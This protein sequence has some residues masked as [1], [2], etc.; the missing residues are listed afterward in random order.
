[1]VFC[2]IKY[3]C[4][5][6]LFVQFA[7]SQTENNIYNALD[8]FVA[9]PT[10]SNLEK[11]SFL[12]KN[13]SLKAKTEPELLALVIL[14]C[15]K[16]YYE[17]QFGQINQA[18]KTYEKSWRIFEINN[19]KNYDIIE[20]CL[21]PLGNLYTKIGDYDSAE[22]TIKQYFFIA[23]Q[24]NNQSQKIASILNLAIVYQSSGRTEASI[25]LVLKTIKEEKLTATE[26]SLLWNNLA[27]NYILN[28]EFEKAKIV[29]EKIIANVKN[30]PNNEAIL[31]NVHRNLA[32][33]YLHNNDFISARL[34][35]NKGKKYILKSKTTSS[36]DLIKCNLEE[37]HLLLKEEKYAACKNKIHSILEQLLPNFDPKKDILPKKNTL[38]AETILLDVFD[39]LA[40]IKTNQKLYQ[41]ALA[42]YE[43]SIYVQEL[44]QTQVLYENS[45]IIN[46][47]ENNIRTEKCLAIYHSLFQK[48]KNKQYVEKAF[49]LSEKSKS[50]VLKNFIKKNAM[51]PIAQKKC[52]EQ[53]QA[54][55]NTIVLEQ[56]KQGKANISIINRNIIIQNKLML[57]LK[58]IQDNNF[59]VE[60]LKI[61]DLYEKLE[62]D[63][64]NLITY[65]S[66][67]EKLYCFKII[68]NKLQMLVLEKGNQIDAFLNYF[69][70]SD[71]ISDDVSG[72]TKSSFNLFRYL[73]LKSISKRKNVIIIP[74]GKLNFIPFD[75]LLTAETKSQNF[76]SLPY[77]IKQNTIS[78]ANSVS[79]YMEKSSQNKSKNTVLGVFPVFKNTIESLPYSQDELKAIKEHFEGTFL[80]N[81]KAT[82]AN[83][84]KKSN[85]YS[86]LHLSTHATSG[87]I[88]EPATIRFFDKEVMY[89]ELYS[90]KINPDL[91]VLSACET[92]IG[93]W[94][95]NEGS[96]SVARGFQQAGAQNLLFSLWKVNDFTTS[97]LMTNFYSNLKNH[98]AFSENIHMAKLDFLADSS[99]SNLKKSPYYWAPFVYYGSVEEV[100]S[101]DYW[102][103]ACV[104]F[105]LFLLTFSIIKYRKVF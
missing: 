99:I 44:L 102:V 24:T 1:M 93:K 60:N 75:A 10:I 46:Q 72:F 2:K 17:N 27:T 104:F 12:E 100:S 67:E 58:E 105:G 8:T 88:F 5:L 90:L 91:V 103:W 4:L 21:K 76:A 62:T 83:F 47:V 41:E 96:M 71:A 87:D 53:L 61:T 31:S 22:N 49:L 56:Q 9:N 3:C 32:S 51:L 77:F 66:G 63:K 16:A 37:T 98:K 23:N 42:T 65:F 15:N 33:I 35:F 97:K 94:Y 34:H 36:R 48:T 11:L 79:F 59:S 45:K 39:V 14:N 80:E 73:E 52:I 29:L 92:G 74:D 84:E 54:T 78:Y 101:N 40:I 38:Y 86:I 19:L 43:L 13:L 81:N 82:F 64:T 57:Q 85:Q 28:K 89:S 6:I 70:N 7:F 50:S 69:V 20:F 55:T 95:K 18:I 25:N 30:T 26:K 68:D